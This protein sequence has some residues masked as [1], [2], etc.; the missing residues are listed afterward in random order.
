MISDNYARIENEIHFDSAKT[1]FFPVFQLFQTYK[2]S[3]KDSKAIDMFQNRFKEMFSKFESEID[4][5]V[6]ITK[7][8]EYNVWG[9]SHMRSY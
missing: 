3:K 4:K 2:L 5:V 1:N 6:T 9:Q 8:M 7:D